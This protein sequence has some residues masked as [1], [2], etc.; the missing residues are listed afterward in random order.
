MKKFRKLLLGLAMPFLATSLTSCAGGFFGG[1]DVVSIDSIETS[2]DE[3]GNTVVTITYTDAD[4]D[5]VTF[6]IP[7]GNDGDKGNGIQSVTQVPDA[8][9]NTVVTITF[10][11]P[12]MEPF[13]TVLKP[14]T[15]IT[16]YETKYD[17]E[18]G[19]T[20]ITFY[21]SNDNPLDPITIYDGDTGKQ[22]VG[23]K[24]FTYIVNDNG[25]TTVTIIFTDSTDEEPHTFDFTL[26]SPVGIS[27]IE[28]SH[29]DGQYVLTLT[30]TN[31]Q[32]EVV[33][34][35]API[36][37][38]S[39]PSTPNVGNPMEGDY[40][41]DTAHGVIYHYENAHWEEVVRFST[42][43]TTYVVSFNLNDDNDAT[44]P[45]GYTSSYTLK[46]GEYFAS[47]GKNLPIPTRYNS[48]TSSYYK[49]VGWS[50]SPAPGP[51]NGYFTDLTPVFSDLTLY[52]IWEE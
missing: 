44:L 3:E 30:Y 45:T 47:T 21:D 12:K 28:P 48:A 19:Q 18:L 11:D 40:F 17:E 24:D 10:T 39:A 33:A 38:Y 34:F 20:T 41:F 32:S 9:G 2:T 4:L 36:N 42:D 49:F 14:G 50:T 16:H 22:G 1:D 26:P 27:S 7:K 15:S 25:T 29:V 35:D 31:G 5:P 6:T 8:F 37:W 51:T 23:I 52:A 13:V 43:E 46:R